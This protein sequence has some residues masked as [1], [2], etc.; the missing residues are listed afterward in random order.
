MVTYRCLTRAFVYGHEWTNFTGCNEIKYSQRL[1]RSGNRVYTT[2]RDEFGQ[3][4]YF[5][6]HSRGRMILYKATIV[7][8]PW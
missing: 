1:T 3:K 8:L 2:K 4:F 6:T 7:W 5:P